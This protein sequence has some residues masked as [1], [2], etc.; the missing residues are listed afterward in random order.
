MENLSAYPLKY[1]ELTIKAK[2]G[3]ILE[4]GC[5]GGRVLRYYKNKGYDIA[6]MDFIEEAIEK[7]KEADPDLD[8]EVGDITNLR[9]K[10]ES[11]RYV[12]A[13]G[14]YHS[15]ERGLEQA[16]R[17]TYRVL[18]KQGKVCASFRADNI[19]TYLTDCLTDY[20]LQKGGRKA[21]PN[22][23]KRFHKMNLTRSEFINLF[24][25]NGFRVESVFHVENM[26]ILY[27]FGFFRSKNHKIFNE[28][29]ARRE[30]YKL[31]FLGSAIQ[32]FVMRYFS[33]KF[34][35]IFVLIARKP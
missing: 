6:G 15:L 21:D 23:K 20:R 14:L 2:E 19:Q 35:N 8:V 34:C 4:A 11:F 28:N 25:S 33:E 9:Y 1:A 22:M 26:P 16:I 5:G 29:L 31:S 17:E 10:S 24:E 13:F 30:G 18:E 3:R 7:L 12:L 27:K 32:Q